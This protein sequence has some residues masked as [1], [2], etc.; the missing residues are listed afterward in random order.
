MGIIFVFLIPPVLFLK[1]LQSMVN[2]ASEIDISGKHR[3]RSEMA[4]VRLINIFIS[5]TVIS[6]VSPLSFNPP[7]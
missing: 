6:L 2:K 3:T 1:E 4:K 5:T 7:F